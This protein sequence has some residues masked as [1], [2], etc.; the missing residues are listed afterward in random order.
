MSGFFSLDPPNIFVE[1]NTI[2][3]NKYSYQLSNIIP[4]TSVMY[5]IFCYND[6][7]EVKYISKLLDG[8][9]YKEWL[10]DDWMDAFIKKKVEEIN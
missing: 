8:E 9:Q 5:H 6:D 1:T 3:I 2:K 10:T 4:H 7:T